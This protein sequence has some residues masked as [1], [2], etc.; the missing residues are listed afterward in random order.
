MYNFCN[1]FKF[2]QE[3]KRFANEFVYHE[4][5]HY[6]IFLVIN[7]HRWRLFKETL[8]REINNRDPNNRELKTESQLEASKTS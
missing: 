1:L 5:I 2:N 3:K 4:I 6:I 7:S 8:E